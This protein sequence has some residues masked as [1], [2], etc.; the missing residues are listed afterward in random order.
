MEW[1]IVDFIYFSA[2]RG[3]VLVLVSGKIKMLAEVYC[4]HRIQKGDTLYPVRNAEYLVNKHPG[5]KAK[6]L[7]AQAYCKDN[8]ESIQR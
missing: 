6:I 1:T 5:Q 3:Y 8:W 2:T 7:S 4:E